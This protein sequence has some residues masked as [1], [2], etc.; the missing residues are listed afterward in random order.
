MDAKI[1]DVDAL[2]LVSLDAARAFG[3]AASGISL[4][5]MVEAILF[6]DGELWGC[7]LDGLITGEEARNRFLAKVETWIRDEFS[8]E[9]DLKIEWVSPEVEAAVDAAMRQD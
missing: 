4:R 2:T 6:D 3:R 5:R 7:L 9:W 8:I 1:P